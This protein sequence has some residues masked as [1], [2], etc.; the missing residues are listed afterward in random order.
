MRGSVLGLSVPLI[1]QE[2]S[3]PCSLDRD[4]PCYSVWESNFQRSKRALWSQLSYPSCPRWSICPIKSHCRES[5]KLLKPDLVEIF[6]KNLRIGMDK[7]WVGMSEWEHQK[8]GCK[9]Q[10]WMAHSS[11]G[12]CAIHV[13]I[14]DKVYIQCPKPMKAGIPRNSRHQGQNKTQAT[15]WTQKEKDWCLKPSKDVSF[16]II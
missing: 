8:K 2:A 4:Q 13:S 5:Q 12:L 9:N 1:L 7:A 11:E 14:R 16:L 3:C 15:E 6:S 10:V